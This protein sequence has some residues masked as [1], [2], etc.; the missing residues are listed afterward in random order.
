MPSEFPLGGQVGAVAR[1]FTTKNGGG[2]TGGLSAELPS[3]LSVP[4]YLGAW[5]PE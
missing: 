2:D 5:I 1:T 4:S 3:V